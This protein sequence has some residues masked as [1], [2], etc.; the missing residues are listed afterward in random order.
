MIG[1]RDRVVPAAEIEEMAREA[2]GRGAAVSKHPEFA[3][4]FSFSFETHRRRFHEVA[5]FLTRWRP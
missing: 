3:H 5:D 4:P 2:Q 1:L